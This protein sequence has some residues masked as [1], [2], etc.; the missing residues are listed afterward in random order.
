MKT[1][2]LRTIAAFGAGV[3]TWEAIV[4]ASLLLNRQTPRLF[5]IRLTPRVN[6]VQSVVPAIFAVAV[7]RYA[8][9]REDRP[10]LLFR[11]LARRVLA[12]RLVEVPLESI[13]DDA[14]RHYATL[15]SGVAK[16]KTAA[17]RTN[18]RMA[19][20]LV[21]LS[22][23]L[24]EIGISAEESHGVLADGVFAVMRRVWWAPDRLAE[25]VHPRDRLARTRMRQRLGRRFYFRD[26]DWSMREVHANGGFGIDVERC[27]MRDF[28]AELGEQGLCRDVLCAQDLK[29]AELRGERLI[30]TSTLAEGA[31]RCDFR[32]LP[33]AG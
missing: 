18:L 9:A 10:P 20:Y 7:A 5:G 11:W 22:G 2:S 4:H 28:L 8:F 21:A 16:A 33:A 24:R 12:G 13:L 30:R 23:A 3:A 27:V 6:F 19:A 14:D 1:P 25:L 26:P 15:V 31:L 32:F 29:M 17:G